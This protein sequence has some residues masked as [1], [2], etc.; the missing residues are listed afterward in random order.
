MINVRA[1]QV[2]QDAILASP[3]L[4]PTVR[5]V[6]MAISFAMHIGGEGCFPSYQLI[7]SRSACSRATAMRAV[8]TLEE[9]GWLGVARTS[10][11]HAN[12]FTLLM[13]GDQSI[14][15]GSET[16]QLADFH[17][18]KAADLRVS[19]PDHA[20]KVAAFS[21]RTRNQ[22]TVSAP[23]QHAANGI[24]QKQPLNG[25]IPNHER[26]QNRPAT[27]AKP[28]DP[29]RE[30]QDSP[31]KPPTQTGTDLNAAFEEL[32]QIWANGTDKGKARSA[33][34]R[35][36]TG[37]NVAPETIISAAR[38]RRLKRLTGHGAEAEPLAR[39]LRREGWSIETKPASTGSP[40]TDQ[41][42]HPTVFVEEGTEAW[43]AWR[44]YRQHLGKGTPSTTF[45]SQG[46]RRGWHFETEFPPSFRSVH[47]G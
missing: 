17:A 43:K 2:W 36:V 42:R 46:G 32:W 21:C 23:I 22:E 28:C 47:H 39:W 20:D 31:L 9:A 4:S 27:V 6:A 34:H 40:L 11:R 3:T 30:E 29:K 45:A 24:I 19:C 35:A 10:G 14:S 13:P 33:F 16:R 15:T 38:E 5:C 12:S 37:L 25:I 41:A 8:K 1:R 26:S 7:A 44:S 18:D